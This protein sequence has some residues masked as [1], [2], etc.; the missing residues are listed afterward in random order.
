MNSNEQ[1]KI[2]SKKITALWNKFYLHVQNFRDKSKI[3]TLYINII[4]EEIV[5]NVYSAN[6]ELV[7][8]FD[9]LIKKDKIDWF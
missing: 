8:E 2:Q 5:Q 7:V 6:L 9:K 1:T 3:K 4:L